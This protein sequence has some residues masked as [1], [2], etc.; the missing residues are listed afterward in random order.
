MVRFYEGGLRTVDPGRGAFIR[1]DANAKKSGE[2]RLRRR[3]IH[4]TR[5]SGL[6]GRL[7]LLEEAANGGVALETNGDFIGVAGFDVRA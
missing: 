3:R 5:R 2:E 1:A 4:S 6:Q 7:T